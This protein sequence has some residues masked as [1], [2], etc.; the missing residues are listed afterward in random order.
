[1]FIQSKITRCFMPIVVIILFALTSLPMADNAFAGNRERSG[2]K[3]YRTERRGSGSSVRQQR[4]SGGES[5]RTERRGSGSSVRGQRARE[6][7]SYRTKRRSVDS[8]VRQ[9]RRRVIRTPRIRRHGHVVSR[10]PRGYR[11]FW[12]N[13]EPFYYYHGVF[14]RPARLGFTVVVAPI[15]IIIDSLPIGYQRIWVD[16][17]WYYTYSGV[18]YRRMPS[19]YVVV[20]TPASIVIEEDITALVEPPEP[21]SGMVSVSASVLNV[22]SGP[23]LSYPVIYQIH[24]DYVLE[25]N[26]KTTG[27]LYVQLPNGEFGWVMNIY[28]TRIEL[29]GS[30]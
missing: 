3:S 19:G 2:G 6:S 21:A 23:G 16:D 14:Y 28:T 17:V 4:R 13:R 29:P 10:L 26:G 8:S 5:Y 27:W 12:Y 25:V 20:E 15:G 7:R 11:R 24:R 22:R 1:M 30:G 18:F 9:Q